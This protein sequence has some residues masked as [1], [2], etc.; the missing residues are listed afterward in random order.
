MQKLIVFDLDC[1]LA[2]SKASL[3]GAMAGVER[4]EGVLSGVVLAYA[5]G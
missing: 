5:P 4:V 2:E 3:D 1:P